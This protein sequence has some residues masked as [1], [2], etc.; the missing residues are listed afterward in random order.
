MSFGEARNLAGNSSY[1]LI[2]LKDFVF[3]SGLSARI[4][5]RV[6]ALQN[7]SLSTGRGM[8]NTMVVCEP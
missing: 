4:C 8:S 1:V 7:P 3:A 5:M 2:D 6:I